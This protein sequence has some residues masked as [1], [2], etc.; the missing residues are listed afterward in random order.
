MKSW[1][2]ADS[3]DQKMLFKEYTLNKDTLQ[4]FKGNP[5]DKLQEFF[6][7]NIPLMVVAGGIDQSVPLFENAGVLL[8]YSANK[9]IFVNSIIQL[10]EKATIG[11]KQ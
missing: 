6:A 11:V 3:N 2:P 10:Q 9:K 4:Q 5:V 8:E 7:L 1:P